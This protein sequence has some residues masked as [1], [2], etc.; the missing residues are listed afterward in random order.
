MRVRARA[1]EASGRDGRASRRGTEEAVGRL[2]NAQD[3]AM[4][5][6]IPYTTLL[7]AARR[8]E[9]PYV[10]IPGCRRWFFDRR[11]LDQAVERWKERAS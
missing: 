5:L 4:Y 10:R 9:I 3:A 11:D 1:D 7:D 6:G 8:G 2:L